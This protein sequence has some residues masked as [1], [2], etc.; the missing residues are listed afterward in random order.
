MLEHASR[1]VD[2]IAAALRLRSL[3]ATLA[4]EDVADSHRRTILGPFWPMLNY[5]L[6]AGTI[7]VIL[8][9]MA[10]GVNFTAYVAAGVLVWNFMN[11]SLTQGATLFLREESFIKGTTLPV[12]VYVLR[13]TMST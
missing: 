8:G 9:P 2:D 7:I 5:A 11:E 10:D 1:G 13:Q 12:S 4:A 3:S 6:F